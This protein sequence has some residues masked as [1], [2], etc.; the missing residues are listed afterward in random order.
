[1]KT[2][3]TDVLVVVD[4]QNDF[5]EGGNVA[6]PGGDEVVPIINDLAKNFKHVVLTQDW[7]PLG[8]LSFASAHQGQ[9]AFS[10]IEMP[11][12]TQTLWPD[13][14]I[15]ERRGS[16][17]HHRLNIPHTELIIRKGFRRE[18]D[19]YSAFFENDHETA[20]GLGGYLKERGFERI[21]LAG[22]AFDYCVR[23][24]AEDAMTLGFETV[25]IE[26]ACRAIDLNDSAEATRNLFRYRGIELL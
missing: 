26:E 11:Y 2:K 20:T 5:C 16:S 4:V 24:S 25:V 14:C 13:H 23:Y 6:V 3:D 22:L 17:L 8:H 19:S 9:A 7:H 21:F 10:Q 18:I 12:G 1:M 15:Q